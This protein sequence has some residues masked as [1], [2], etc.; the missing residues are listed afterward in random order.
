MLYLGKVWDATAGRL[1]AIR[2][3]VG[4]TGV[5][6]AFSRLPGGGNL[7]TIVDLQRLPRRIGQALFFD[8]FL[9][10]DWNRVRPHPDDPGRLQQDPG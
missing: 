8:G 4:K 3:G 9:S 2:D 7:Y 6:W 5:N 10:G 1:G